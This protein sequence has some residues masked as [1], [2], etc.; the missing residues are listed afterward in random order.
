MRSFENLSQSEPS[1]DIVPSSLADIESITSISPKTYVLDTNVLLHDPESISKFHEHTV[2]LPSEVLVEMDRKKTAEGQVGAN[3]RR[4]HRLLRDMFDARSL[5][6]CAKG[7]NILEAKMPNGGRISLVI[8][9]EEAFSSEDVKKLN[10]VLI[11]RHQTDHRI[12]AAA[13][14]L[15]KNEENPVI[16]VS[17]DANMALKGKLLGL[18]VED[19][20]NDRISTVETDGYREIIVDSDVFEALANYEWDDPDS[21]GFP[22]EVPEDAYTNEY[23]LVKAEEECYHGIVEP[24]RYLGDGFVDMLPLYRQHLR[25]DVNRSDK[26][27]LQMPN[28]IR[29]IPRNVEQWIHLDALMNPE[30]TLVTCKGKAGTGKTFLAMASA[31]H[32]VLSENSHYQR[33]LISRPIVEMGRG[34]GYLPGTKEEKMGPY[35]QPYFDNL[36]VLFPNRKANKQK[37]TNNGQNPPLKVWERFQQQGILEIEAL[38]YIRGRSIPNSLLIVDEAQNLTPHE[39]KTVVTRLA[40]GSK[41]ILLGDPYQIDNPFLDARTNG[42]VYARDRLKGQPIAVHTKLVEGVRSEIAEL[43]ADLL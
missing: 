24:V 16:L 2:V 9:G 8:T 5:Q 42:L 13:Y 29:V 32:E 40:H 10:A 6:E 12:L 41:L 3:A 38:T 28:G 4:V 36:E 18:L 25:Q 7:E 26:N 1:V 17:K 21:E 31:L 27:G 11:D 14:A 35:M 19:Y 15:A 43:G 22:L 37:N 30:I 34:I 39:V 33:L 20:R 23:F